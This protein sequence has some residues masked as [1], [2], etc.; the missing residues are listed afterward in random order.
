MPNQKPAFNLATVMDQHPD[1]S[2]YG[3]GVYDAA[4]KS[5][6]DQAAELAKSRATLAAS[7]DDVQWVAKWLIEEISPIA[8]PT[9]SSYAMKHV[10]ERATGKYVSNGAF[11][12]GAL[13]AGYAM[14]YTDD[15]NPL[16]GM[17]DRDITRL[18]MH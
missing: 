14:T 16:F 1:L 10:M 13:V 8:T 11:I 7:D 15:P 2:D 5:P 9:V 4:H 3:I 6:A 18:D 12:A 17:S